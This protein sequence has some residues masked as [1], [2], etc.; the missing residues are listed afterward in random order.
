MHNSCE[1]VKPVSVYLHSKYFCFSFQ[2]VQNNFLLLS[3][4]QHFFALILCGQLD[5]AAAKARSVHLA[6]LDAAGEGHP[7]E[8]RWRDME[9]EVWNAAKDEASLAAF[10]KSWQSPFD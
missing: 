2:F 7:V 1:T 9:R 6:Y 5:A 10:I 3:A 8:V 4:Q